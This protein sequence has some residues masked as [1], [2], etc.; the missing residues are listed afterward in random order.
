MH[1]IIN[2]FK[3]SLFITYLN[4]IKYYLSNFSFQKAIATLFCMS[5]KLISNDGVFKVLFLVKI[6]LIKSNSFAVQRGSVI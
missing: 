1:K 2:N 4:K 3:T 6:S 5:N